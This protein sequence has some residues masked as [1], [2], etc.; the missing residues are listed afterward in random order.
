MEE[1]ARNRRRGEE[2]LGRMGENLR[3]GKGV[4]LS[5]SSC[6][7][8]SPDKLIQVRAKCWCICVFS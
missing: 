4:T 8:E 2:V 1:G 5:V 7:I 3:F 6:S